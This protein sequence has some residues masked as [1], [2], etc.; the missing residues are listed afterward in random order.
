[1]KKINIHLN[2]C[3]RATSLTIIIITVMTLWSEVSS[4]FKDLL[5]NL[6]GHH[7]VSKGVIALLFYVLLYGVLS[8]VTKNKFHGEREITL[9]TVTTILCSLIIFLFYLWH[10]FG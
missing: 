4:G 5:T 9:I 6:T 3:A 2:A 1:M 8:F 10:Y 7:W